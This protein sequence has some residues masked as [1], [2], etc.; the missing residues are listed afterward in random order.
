MT[1]SFAFTL[2]S[3]IARNDWLDKSWQYGSFKCYI[4]LKKKTI[5]DKLYWKQYLKNL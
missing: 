5:R 4:I 2:Y 3:Q 1:I